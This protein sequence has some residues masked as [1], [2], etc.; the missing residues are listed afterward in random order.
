MWSFRPVSRSSIVLLFCAAVPAA[1]RD[2]ADYL[3]RARKAFDSKQFSAAV[4]ELE[5]AAAQ[6]PKQARVHLALGQAQ[7]LV[8]KQ[9]EAEKSLQAAL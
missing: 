7:Y 8:G 5:A 6:C 9:E 3:D 1:A 2:C 4:T